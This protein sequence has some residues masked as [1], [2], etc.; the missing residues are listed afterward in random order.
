MINRTETNLQDVVKDITNFYDKK[1]WHFLTLNG[2]KLDEE[3]TEIQWIFTKYGVMEEIVMFYTKV[4]QDEIIPSIVDI[5]PSAIIS[6]REI[7]DMFGIEVE[8]SQ[9]GLYLDI[10]SEQMPLSSCGV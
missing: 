4:K 10:D 3:Y 1:I 8:N 7:V 5:L 6:Q 9:K 2:V